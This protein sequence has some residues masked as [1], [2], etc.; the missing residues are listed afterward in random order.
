[1]H[2]K[3]TI[4]PRY[5]W[6]RVGPSAWP[7]CVVIGLVALFVN[8]AFGFHGLTSKTGLWGGSLIILLT[9]L[10]PLGAWWDSLKL[11]TLVGMSTAQELSNLKMAFALFI[12]SELFFFVGLFWAFFHSALS[13]SDELGCM[14]PPIVGIM[15]MNPYSLPTVG[16]VILVSSGFSINL[17][18]KSVKAGSALYSTMV[19]TV[20]LGLA[21]T[22]LQ[23]YEYVKAGF[24]MQD[25]IYGSCFYVIT[26]FHGLHVIAGTLFN[27]FCLKNMVAGD[28]SRSQMT[29]LQ[30]A[31]WYWHFVDLVW[32]FAYLMIYVWGN[33]GCYKT[34]IGYYSPYHSIVL[35]VTG[36]VLPAPLHLLIPGLHR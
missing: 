27:M 5:S 14:W 16:L 30:L 3:T 29:T 33:W 13:P 17:A 9:L 12:W 22:C 25:G 23:V 31:A 8:L 15:P 26:G 20:L 2:N 34:V 28:Y 4:V 10:L 24:T 1:M 7:I 18:V 36:F 35:L 11:E 32:I 21:F 6:A 19:V